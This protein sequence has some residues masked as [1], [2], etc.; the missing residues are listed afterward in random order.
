[1]F[2]RSMPKRCLFIA[3]AAA[4]VT[5]VFAQEKLHLDMLTRI[6]QEGFRHSQVM[7]TASE[8]DD[9]IGP[10]LTAS[11]NMARAN[12]WTRDQ[13]SQWGLA[14]APLESWGTYYRGWK[15]QAV[16]LRM[17]SPDVTNFIAYP[18]PWTP[19]TEGVLHGK[20]IKVKI[21]KKEDLDEYKGKL[22][23]KIVLF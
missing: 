7:Q 5:P 13:L 16:S 18:K 21:E 2:S 19:S 6:R 9:R 17:L 15:Q 1:M 10:R 11:P 20:V 8:L 3:L 14:N 23:G 22:A 4:L 12:E